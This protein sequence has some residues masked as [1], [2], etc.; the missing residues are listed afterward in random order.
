MRLKTLNGAPLSQNLRFDEHA[1]LPRN[2][3]KSLVASLNATISSTDAT[4]FKWRRLRGKDTRLHTGWSQPY[5]PGSDRRLEEME[6]SITMPRVEQSSNFPDLESTQ[7]DTTMGLGEQS[8]AP[9]TFLQHSLVFHDTLLS[10]QVAQDVVEGD[11]T[12]S[13]SSF[14]TTSFGTTISEPNSEGNV[15][16]PALMLQVP[17][18]MSLTALQSLPTAQHLRSIYPQTPTPNFLCALMTHP[19]RREVFVRKGGYTMDLYE[20]TVADDTSS[21]FKVSFWL[22]PHSDHN[23]TAQPLLKIL[24]TIKVGD[25]LLLRNIALTAFRDTVYGQSLNPSIA[26]ARTTVDVLMDSSGSHVGH[27]GGLPASMVESFVRVKRWA[28]THVAP[29]DVGGRKRRR[30][31]NGQGQEGKRK[32]ASSFLDD[33]LP[34]DTLASI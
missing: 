33:S 18:K 6:A 24:E 28:K 9:D 10:S 22:R 7:L 1:L 31:S 19:E 25:I 20:V 5:L 8:F 2:E 13:S 26:R 4:T 34:P 12:I 15:E 11:Q 17:P 21:G 3:C 30:T 14:L 27:L 32:T 16:E 23:T 29:P